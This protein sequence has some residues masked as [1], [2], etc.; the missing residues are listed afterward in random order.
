MDADEYLEDDGP[1]P[2]VAAVL[3][4]L[5]AKDANVA[6]AAEAAFEW[7]LAGD[8][9][10]SLTQERIQLFCWYQLPYKWGDELAG[11]FEV[12][13]SLARALELL[14]LP[15]YAAICLSDETRTILEAFEASYKKGMAAF[16]KADLSSGLRPPDLEDFA[17]GDYC[18]IVESDAQSEVSN[19]LELAISSGDLVPGSK[20]FK[21]AQQSLTRSFLTAPRDGSSLLERIRAERI[22]AWITDRRSNIR[23]ELFAAIEPE[24]RAPKVLPEGSDPLPRMRWLLEQIKDGQALTKTGNLNR[25]FVQRAAPAYDW[26]LSHLPQSE[27]EITELWVTRE[28]MA[29]R[30]L[31]RRS[32]SKLLASSKGKCLLADPEAF[33]NEVC[34]GLLDI[35]PFP[36]AAGEVL[37]AAM[38]GGEQNYQRFCSKVSAAILQE[39]FHDAKGDPPVRDQI[40]TA[41]H[42]TLNLIRSLGLYEESGDWRD[43]RYEF[44]DVGRATAIQALWSR[45]TGPRFTL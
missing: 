34:R 32:G 15:R 41:M 13:A 14:Q 16:K 1:D 4:E 6:E 27:D 44:T 3:A 12:L 25:A 20:G 7:V 28:F 45:A 23:R 40:V 43:R 39:G 26:D 30:K 35:E 5:S 29:R 22:E 2:K 37:L 19:F 38:A 31:T 10:E 24:I 17:W 9:P 33:W 8:G 42:E 11:K 18:G 21:A 36:A